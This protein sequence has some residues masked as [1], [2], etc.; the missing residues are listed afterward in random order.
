MKLLLST[1]LEKM[2]NGLAVLEINVGKQVARES[3]PMHTA[4]TPMK[5][6]PSA[7]EKYSRS[8]LGERPLVILSTQMMTSCCIISSKRS[9]LDLSEPTQTSA[10][11][12]VLFAHRLL[13]NMTNAGERTL[14]CGGAEVMLMSDCSMVVTMF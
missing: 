13:L 6:G 5:S 12:P 2:G 10:P 7:M 14:N 3:Q 11:V 1:T 4:C 8:T 9:G